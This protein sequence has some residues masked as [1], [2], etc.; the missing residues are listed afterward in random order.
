V[1]TTVLGGLIAVLQCG[2]GDL[3]A[4]DDLVAA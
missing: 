1:S 2:I 3:I 4:I